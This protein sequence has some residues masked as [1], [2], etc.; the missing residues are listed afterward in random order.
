[1]RPSS[2]AGSRS[3][4]VRWVPTRHATN[5]P[6]ATCLSRSCRAPTLTAVISENPEEPLACAVCGEEIDDDPDTQLTP[7][8]VWIFGE[9]YRAREFDQ[10]LWESGER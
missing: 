4:A 6:D 2:K 9:C 1:M 8:G 7:D 10:L 5:A 3:A